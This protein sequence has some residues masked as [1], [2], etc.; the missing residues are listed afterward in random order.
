M[1]KEI[2]FDGGT[3]GVYN[4]AIIRTA[5]LNVYNGTSSTEA[6][7][8]AHY[9]TYAQAMTEQGTSGFYYLD[10]PITLPAGAYSISI[11]ERSGSSVSITDSNV[12]D[13][14]YDWSGYNAP[15][16]APAGLPISVSDIKNRLVGVQSWLVRASQADM[17]YTDTTIA[18]LI[19]S[20]IRRFEQEVQIRINPVQC[21][22]YNDGLYAPKNQDYLN[23]G[24]TP[25]I[26]ESPYHYFKDDAAEFFKLN[27]KERPVT[28][29][30]RIRLMWNQDDVI[31]TVPSNWITFD[32]K[33][34]H[35]NLL[36]VRGAAQ[37]ASSAIAL[38]TLQAA[39]GFKSYVPNI[40]AIDYTAG[41]PTN[42]TV[43]TEYAALFRALTEYCAYA[44]LCDIGELYYAGHLSVHVDDGQGMGQTFNLSRFEK[45]KAELYDSVMKF[46]QTWAG[47]ETPFLFSVV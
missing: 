44:V 21:A 20:M 24:T 40:I 34:G 22:C 36:A 23:D 10:F 42:W 8:D 1:S 27:T 19:P 46:Q 17:A 4:Y 16:T 12:G 6:W 28:A 11:K 29:V 41:L 18:N 26:N 2:Q 39:F 33:S 13:L 31:M 14:S 5:T 47:T 35:I 37:Y 15:A 45:R 32:R 3:G 25:I 9:S 30:Q 43:L 38:T 7:N